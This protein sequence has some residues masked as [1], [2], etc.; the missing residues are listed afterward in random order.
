MVD[1]LFK[2]D[3]T[4]DK[5][6]GD[7]IIALFG[8]PLE[9]LDAPL[10]AVTCALEMQRALRELNRTR[11][12]EMHEPIRIGMGINTGMVVTGAIGSSKALQY[13][14]IGDA[15]NTASRLCSA[16]KADEIIVSESTMA[17]IADHVEAAAM[18]PIEVKGK[19]DKLSIYNVLALKSESWQR[20]ATRTV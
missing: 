5:F 8:A 15:M 17:K 3:G 18:T 6:V 10:K 9:M 13:T 20:D 14:A 12:A 4:L 2:F 11:A 7:E 16:A 19:R 1:I